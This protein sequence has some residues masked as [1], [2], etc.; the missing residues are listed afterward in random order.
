MSR[1]FTET[2]LR[3]YANIRCCTNNKKS[4]SLKLESLYVQILSYTIYDDNF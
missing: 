1:W 2:Q 4:E 3:H